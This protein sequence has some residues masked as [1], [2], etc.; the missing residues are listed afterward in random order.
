MKMPGVAD[1]AVAPFTTDG[2]LAFDPSALADEPK[3]EEAMRSAGFVRSPDN[4]QIGTWISPDGVLIDLFV[5]DAVGGTG[6]RAAKLASHGDRVARKARGLEA[7]LVDKQI[8]SI[9]ALDE[10]DLRHLDV[11]VAGPTGLLIAKLHKIKDR[12]DT[13]NRLDDKDALDVFRLL[14]AIPNSGPFERNTSPTG[15]RYF[16]LSHC[17][18]SRLSQD[19]VWYA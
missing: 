14:Q 11:W 10:L 12:L 8:M 9:G 7:I 3:I 1:L 18:G 4:N 13:P 15:G 5:P 6:R 2:D 19:A 16:Q 17:S